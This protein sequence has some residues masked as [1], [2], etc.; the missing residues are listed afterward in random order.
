MHKFAHNQS[1]GGGV[2]GV[3]GWMGVCVCGGGGGV[4]VDKACG[5]LLEV[6]EVLLSLLMSFLSGKN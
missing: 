1:F 6:P 4:E 3:G 2:G 5:Y